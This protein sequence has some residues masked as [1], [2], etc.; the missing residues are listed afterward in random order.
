MPADG[1][2]GDDARGAAP[3]PERLR[4]DRPRAGGGENEMSALVRL[5]PRAWRER[6]EAEFLTL[7][8][9]RPTTIG[10]RLDIVRGA[11]DARLHPQVR[12]DEAP[13]PAPNADGPAANVGLRP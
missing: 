1:A 8:E 13:E 2:G 4:R 5:Y 9:A 12:R 11:L 3:R 6:Y 7:L 10:D